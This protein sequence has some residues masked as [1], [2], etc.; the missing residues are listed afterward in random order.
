MAAKTPWKPPFWLIAVDLLAAMM[1][2]L[3]FALRSGP[4]AGLPQTA[5]LPLMV[6]G[7]ALLG[8]CAVVA[9]R[10]VLAQRRDR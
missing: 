3:G 8:L 10:L 1:L 4:L 2:F 6:V 9:V 5:A 7:G